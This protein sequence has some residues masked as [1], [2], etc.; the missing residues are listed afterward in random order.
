MSTNSK[1]KIIAGIIIC[2]ISSSLV[3]FNVIKALDPVS[4][5]VVA[6]D[7]VSFVVVALTS[8][9]VMLGLSCAIDN[10]YPETK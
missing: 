9:M 5:V 10:L 3:L 6:L 8:A 4:F 7:P 2:G 1:L